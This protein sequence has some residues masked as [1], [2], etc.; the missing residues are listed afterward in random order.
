MKKCTIFSLET[1]DGTINDQ[2]ASREHVESYYKDLFGKEHGGLISLGAD[3]WLDKGRP[4]DEE[5]QNLIKPFTLKEL[6]D[7]LKDMDPN[8]SPGPDGLFVSF[9][10]NFGQKPKL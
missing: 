4:S 9:I 7:A 6:G 2:Q 10:K 5:A 8:A 3:F 1:E